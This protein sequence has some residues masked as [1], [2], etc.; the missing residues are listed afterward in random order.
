MIKRVK[1]GYKV[2]SEKT[3]KNL[4]GPHKAKAGAEKC[5][6]QVEFFKRSKG[7]LETKSAQAAAA[8]TTSRHVLD[9]ASTARLVRQR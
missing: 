7:W 4:G 5:L 1:G 3:H 6:R 8:L 9:C 2:L